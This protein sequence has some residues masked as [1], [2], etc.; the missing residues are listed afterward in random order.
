M[1]YESGSETPAC[2]SIDK[3]TKRKGDDHL[4]RKPCL[5]EARFTAKHRAPFFL[6]ATKDK[7][8]KYQ[9]YQNASN[10]A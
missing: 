4:H 7:K 9:E 5:S 10:N 2:D 8:K 1:E 3:N 6:S